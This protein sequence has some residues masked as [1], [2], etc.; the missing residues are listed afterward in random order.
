VFSS[1]SKKDLLFINALAKHSR[2]LCVAMTANAQSGHTGGAL[3]CMDILATLYVVSILKTNNPI[4]ISNGHISP[5][6]YALLSE[7]GAI[8]EAYLLKNFRRHNS[9]YEGHVSRHVPGVWYST[10]PLGAGVSA[11]TGFAFAEK[12]KKEG[13][14]VY[15]LLGDGEAEEGQVY[16][17]MHVAKKYQLD[18]LVVFLDRNGVQLSGSTET[19]MPVPIEAHFEVAGWRVL[20]V[21]GHNPE[22]IVKAL[23][24]PN[25]ARVPTL[26]SCTT[27]MGKGVSFM[28]KEGEAYRATWHGKAP[29]HEQAVK[30]LH[31]LALTAKEEFI[32][33]EGKEE[34]A[35][36]FSAPVFRPL[37]SIVS[38]QAGTPHVYTSD[39]L[40]DCRSAYGAAL[41]DLAKANK[42]IIALTADLADS[43]KTSLVEKELPKQHIDC[44]IAEQH[45]VSMAGGLSLSGFVP[46]VSTFGVFMTSRA[47]DQARVNDIN[48]TNVKTVATHCGLSVGE[49]G[50]THQAIDDMG[51]ML[52]LFHTMVMEPADPNQ[53]DRMIRYAATHWGNMYIRMGRHKVPVITREDGTPWY[54]ADYIYTYGRT[55]RI[56]EGRDVTIIAT[57][58]MVGFSLEAR[59]ILSKRKP[60]ISIEIIAASSIKQFDDTL[61]ESLRQ[62]KK[63]VTIEDHNTLSGLG[64][65]IALLLTDMR[66]TPERFERIG[67][68]HYMNSGTSEELY[69]AAELSPPHLANRLEKILAS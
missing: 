40:T 59:D 63:I 39:T 38:L 60:G 4:V 54:G 7:F 45:M 26:I 49:D 42:E 32:L 8:P 2:A 55:D 31:E 3:G 11:A 68:E 48:Q 22:D 65:Q 44:G 17:M 12:A 14:Y 51:S 47:K 9:M 56:R 6:V 36:Q 27:T 62:A 53:C 23:N 33:K 41:L 19:I 66:L 25:K 58:P 28:E 52:G 35:R 5:A 64:S 67:V 50:P 34:R 46:F 15:A 18:N 57:G 1:L 69:E 29:N 30:A 37:R 10:G 21:D 24:R 16:E 61:L 13:S 43:V 20:H